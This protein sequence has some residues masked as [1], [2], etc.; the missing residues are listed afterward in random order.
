M[1][2]QLNVRIDESVKIQAEELLHGLGLNMSTAINLFARAIIREQGLPFDIKYNDTSFTTQERK[3][4]DA[5]LKRAESDINS[6]STVNAHK[7]I[8]EKIAQL[9]AM[10]NV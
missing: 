4:I 7:Y 8:S 1:T 2:T 3:M 5:G 9:E 6:G 10:K